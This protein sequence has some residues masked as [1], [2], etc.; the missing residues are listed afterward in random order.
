MNN[1]ELKK[2]NLKMLENITAEELNK[3]VEGKIDAP[4]LEGLPNLSQLGKIEY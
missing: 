4:D 1:I 3:L 2:V